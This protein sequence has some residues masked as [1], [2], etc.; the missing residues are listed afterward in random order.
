MSRSAL[1]D[2]A[3]VGPKR[4]AT[5]LVEFGSLAALGNASLED[6]ARIPGIGERLARRIYENLHG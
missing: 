4:S 2:I 6:I 1:D 5:L 3:G